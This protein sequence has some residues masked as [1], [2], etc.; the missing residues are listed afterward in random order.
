LVSGIS[1]WITGFSQ[2]LAFI[3][4]LLFMGS[5]HVGHGYPVLT[6]RMANLH[7]L[8]FGLL[9][10]HVAAFW[11]PALTLLT[12]AALL[13]FV[14]QV[15]ISNR[16]DAL[17]L[18][19]VA[20]TLLSYYLFIHDLSVLLLPLVVCLDRS[21]HGEADG[22]SKARLRFRIA[23]LAFVSPLLISY[24][25]EYFYLAAVPFV[26]LLLLLST[27]WRDQHHNLVLATNAGIAAN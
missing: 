21:L 18:A 19:I 12:S 10:G 7:G 24:A 25:G 15:Q 23:V 3:R 17:F 20:S 26:A 8:I 6:Q 11:I 16:G 9:G 13:T 5:S 22:D 2:A 14:T 4:I 1:L 27:Q